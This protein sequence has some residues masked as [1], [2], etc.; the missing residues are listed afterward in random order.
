MNIYDE[1]DMR[2]IRHGLEKESIEEMK[3]FLVSLMLYIEQLSTDDELDIETKTI[4][5]SSAIEFSVNLAKR[6]VELENEE[7]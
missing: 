3:G 1:I 6:I 4:G 2:I 7:D 5:A